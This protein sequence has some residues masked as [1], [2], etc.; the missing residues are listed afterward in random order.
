MAQKPA[1]ILH[2]TVAS[3]AELRRLNAQEEARKLR[4]LRQ[5]ADAVKPVARQVSC[6]DVARSI[7]VEALRAEPVSIPALTLASISVG[8]G[9]V[10]K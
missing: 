10:G 2:K 5:R 8:Y 4:I 1:Q 9:I 3:F 7:L 6:G